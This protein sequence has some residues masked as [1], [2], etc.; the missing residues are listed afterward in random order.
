V[1]PD[2]PTNRAGDD[3]YHCARLKGDYLQ[4]LPG[5]GRHTLTNI[6][7]RKISRRARSRPVY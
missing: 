5:R 4:R 3:P 6:L 1:L 7:K 2:L